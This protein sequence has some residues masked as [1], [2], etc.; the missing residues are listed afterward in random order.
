MTSIVGKNSIISGG[1]G[2]KGGI[3]SSKIVGASPNEI[4]VSTVESLIDG[5][6][7][8]GGSK[9]ELE[10]N[11]DS[12]RKEGKYGCDPVAEECWNKTE[13]FMLNV[14]YSDTGLKMFL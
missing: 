9:R 6:Q 2:S 10:G 13:K 8:E 14:L 3:S 12:S 5:I 1:N 4:T 11:G 7:V